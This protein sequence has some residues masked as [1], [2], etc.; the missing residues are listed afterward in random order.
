MLMF[1]LT[2]HVV[3]TRLD[4]NAAALSGALRR[5]RVLHANAEE[6][7]MKIP[8]RV[9]HLAQTLTRT[10]PSER[11]FGIILAVIELLRALDAG[12]LA[13]RLAQKL[14]KE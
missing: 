13:D 3:M 7:D 14:I 6:L 9:A 10:R 2:L 4:R 11:S 12:E 8:A 5:L 1:A